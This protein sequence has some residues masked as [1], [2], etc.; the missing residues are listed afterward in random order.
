MA[1]TTI[2]ATNLPGSYASALVAV[3]LTAA[4]VANK[5]QCSLANGDILLVQNSG[6]SPHNV[7][8][9]SIADEY[10]RLGS[11]TSEA[12]AAGVVKSFGP[13]KEPGWQQADG[14]L[15]FEADHAE[16]KFAVLRQP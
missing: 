13:F 14:M 8:I 9:T 2:S 6:A 4:D 5:N 10:G 15:Y 11:I 3:T 12:V 7:T 16:I 1:R